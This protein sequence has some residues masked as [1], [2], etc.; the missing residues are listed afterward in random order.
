MA[1]I[2]Y[3]TTITFGTSGLTGELLSVDGMSLERDAV[4]TTYMASAEQ[5]REFIP[6]LRNAGEISFEMA[7]DPTEDPDTPITGDVETITV[8]WPDDAT[9]LTWA[10]DGFLTSFQPS[11]P[12]DDRITV[13][14]TIKLTGVPTFTTS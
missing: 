8:T 1:R 12:I 13:S 5:W 2:G 3:G 10:C 6:G 14:G 11:A 4:E 7:F 9:V